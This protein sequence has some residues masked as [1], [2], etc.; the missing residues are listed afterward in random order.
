MINQNFSSHQD[1]NT[2][3]VHLQNDAKREEL[4]VDYIHNLADRF[5]ADLQIYLEQDSSGDNDMLNNTLNGVIDSVDKHLPSSEA[6]EVLLEESRD[7]DLLVTGASIIGHAEHPEIFSSTMQLAK[8]ASCPVMHIPH[9]IRQMHNLSF[10]RP[11]VICNSDEDVADVMDKIL[12][13]LKDSSVSIMLSHYRTYS[14]GAN[15]LR[16]K[17]DLADFLQRH[18]ISCRLVVPEHNASEDLDDMVDEINSGQYDFVIMRAYGRSSMRD[19]FLGLL[20]RAV[21]S[22]AQIPVLLTS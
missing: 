4:K 14:D 1:V 11:V 12:P 3:L 2:I 5:D 21:M 19:L 7:V 15:K 9:R 13:F 8:E 20:P 10:G 18:N 6:Y 22:H 17:Q 16:R